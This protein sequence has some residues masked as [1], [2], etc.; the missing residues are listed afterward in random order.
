ML[1]FA[2]A[3]IYLS[4]FLVYLSTN[5][6]QCIYL[7][8]YLSI[9]LPTYESIYLFYLSFLSFYLSIYLS[10]YPS[11][12]LSIYPSIYLS[13]YLGC[14]SAM[15]V[16]NFPYFLYSCSWRFLIFCHFPGVPGV[17]TSLA[18]SSHQ[19]AALGPHS[20]SLI[21][22]MVGRELF[23]ARGGHIPLKWGAK[24]ILRVSQL[25]TSRVSQLPTSSGMKG[26]ML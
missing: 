26:L 8:T 11:I 3:F 23:G 18:V 10:I 22:A 20:P 16:Y 24:D 4:T 2:H 17:P 7:P 5:R 25:P 1:S 6:I 9:D 19:L 13:I 15:V 14:T 12:H 21:C